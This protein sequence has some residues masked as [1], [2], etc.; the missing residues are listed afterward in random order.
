M[1]A[2]VLVSACEDCEFSMEGVEGYKSGDAVLEG[3]RTHR[4]RHPAHR[5]TSERYPWKKASAA[6]ED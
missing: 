5:I 3:E 6:L 1:S 2:Y 4:E